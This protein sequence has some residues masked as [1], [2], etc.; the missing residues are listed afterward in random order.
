MTSHNFVGLRRRSRGET[1]EGRVPSGG[2]YV[3]V[4]AITINRV[5]STRRPRARARWNAWRRKGKGKERKARKV[6]AHLNPSVDSA[7]S[8]PS[9]ATALIPAVPRSLSPL[10]WIRSSSFPDTRHHTHARRALIHT[11]VIDHRSRLPSSAS[12]LAARSVQVATSS[13]RV[14]PDRRKSPPDMS[15]C[16]HQHRVDRFTRIQWATTT[17][18][19]I[20]FHRWY[21]VF[22]F[23]F[24]RS[25]VFFSSSRFFVLTR[26]WKFIRV[27]RAR[28]VDNFFVDPLRWIPEHTGSVMTLPTRR[29]ASINAATACLRSGIWVFAVKVRTIELFLS[30]SLVFSYSTLSSILFFLFDSFRSFVIIHDETLLFF[31][32]SRRYKAS[33]YL[34]GS[35]VRFNLIPFTARYFAV[36]L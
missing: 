20:V 6:K 28:F 19:F 22:L 12:V 15:Q 17:H 21:T 30:L 35:F 5:N 11:G 26:D 24:S 13:R 25:Y 3:T 1:V 7:Q 33:R 4:H 18:H 27:V 16:T 10:A 23:S 29:A 9:Q 32:R 36:C 2:A 14:R 34:N 8:D 31:Q